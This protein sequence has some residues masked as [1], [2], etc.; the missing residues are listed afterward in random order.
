VQVFDLMGQ[1]VFQW[2][3]PGGGEEP[4]SEIQGIGID[5]NNGKVY[6]SDAGNHQVQV[7]GQGGTFSSAWGDQ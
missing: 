2:S 5:P 1:L 4:T 6:V 7:F 3:I